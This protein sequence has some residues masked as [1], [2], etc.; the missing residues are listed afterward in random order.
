MVTHHTALIYTMVLVSAADGDMTDAELAVIGGIIRTL[1]VFADYDTD[2][3]TQAAAECDE[4]LVVADG[5]GTVVALIPQPLPERRL[6]P[7]YA[8]AVR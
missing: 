1:P 3:L 2:L 8:L 6:C 7:A 5:F 4:L